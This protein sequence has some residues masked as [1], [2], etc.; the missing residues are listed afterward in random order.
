MHALDGAGRRGGGEKRARDAF[1]RQ[2]RA[3][4]GTH[5]PFRGRP[6]VKRTKY[7]RVNCTFMRSRRYN[8]AKAV[9]GD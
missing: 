6:R 7:R 3:C 9:Q 1:A 2:D 8:K 5:I 4:V